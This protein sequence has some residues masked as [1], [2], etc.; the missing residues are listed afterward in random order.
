M[1]SLRFLLSRRWLLFALVVVVLCYATWW[2]GEWQFHRL[3][4]RKE[5]NRVIR[6]NED[7]APAP[8]A[9]VLSP[10][11]TVADADE[12]RLVTATGTYPLD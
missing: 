11:G 10:G 6:A 4:D 5:S 1:R 8:V 12:W 7:R 2:L 3:A 9:D